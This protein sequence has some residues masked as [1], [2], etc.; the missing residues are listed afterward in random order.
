MN[1]QAEGKAHSG[2]AATACIASLFPTSCTSFHS[3][4]HLAARRYHYLPVLVNVHVGT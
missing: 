1:K 3:E 4:L 2:L